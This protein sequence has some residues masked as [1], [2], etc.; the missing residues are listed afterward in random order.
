M[1]VPEAQ[2]GLY[3]A[4]GEAQAVALATPAA[5]GLVGRDFTL[6][7]WIQ[8]QGLRADRDLP[9]FGSDQPTATGDIQLLVRNGL[10]YVLLNG[11]AIT[12]NTPLQADCW[13]HVA[14]RYNATTGERVLLLNGVPD[15]AATGLITLDDDLTLMIGRLGS[16]Y[17][18]G[19]ITEVRLWHEAR[20]ND[21]LQANLYRRLN[22]QE[23]KL[24]GY[25]PLNEG[26]GLV[27]TDRRAPISES[28]G[29]PVS[30]ALHN[31]AIARD[32]WQPATDPPLR[33]L[34]PGVEAATV[35]VA[36]FPT[37]DAGLV[38]PNVP[39]LIITNTLTVE[40]WVRA[41]ASGRALEFYP[42]LSM[43]SDAKGWE[44]RCDGSQCAF[45]VTSNG[46]PYT[47]TSGDLAA[48]AWYHVAGVY[49]G[50]LVSLY[51][52]GV[53]RSILPCTGAITPYP[54]ALGIGCNTYWNDR[55]FTGQLAEVRLWGRARTQ[56]EIQQGLFR[57]LAG[58]E[59]GLI[60]V[61]SLE[62]DGSAS[63]DAISATPRGA[64]LWTRAGVPLPDTPLA[65]P[66]ATAKP[67]TGL[68][69]QLIAARARNAALV[70]Q[71]KEL[72]EARRAQE[73]QFI[74]QFEQLRKQLDDVTSQ[75]DYLTHQ[76]RQLLAA[77]DALTQDKAR[78]MAEKEELVKG[79]GARTTL[80]DFVQN[81]ND[82]IKRARAELRRQGGAYSLERVSLE[83]KMLPGPAGEGMFFPQQADLGKAEARLIEP[84]HLSTLSLEF[85]AHDPQEKPLITPLLVPSVIGYTEIMAR[86]KLVEAGFLV[87]R[88]FQAVVQK[89][90]EPIQA[91]RVVD[92]L[93]HPGEKWPP[94]GTITI[95]I[96]R[97]TVTG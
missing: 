14:L 6:E 71:N 57:R 34:T 17:F 32:A 10:L 95:F 90:N 66:D 74:K 63:N 27:A 65:E 39:A 20:T 33:L 16:A 73:A 87:A 91:D 75:L 96:G 85:T 51:V 37:V 1:L 21:Q 13:Y 62:G 72:T 26:A 36:E 46:A 31:G 83:V 97:E 42:L 38:A 22:G 25:W 3:F 12:G 53:R 60:G 70:Q 89:P 15:A 77:N 5:L 93:P 47:V 50:H 67:A 76:H 41:T 7:A 61:W 86:R 80:H 44:L 69:A 11:N 92:Q 81:A 49:D 23:Q 35:V 82:S 18:R 48:N 79:G 45:V 59:A 29:Q 52:N 54:G 78:L 56:A 94:G 19:L 58:D 64:V 88:D 2:S 68:R 9:V 30:V 4:E 8:P 28:H 84:D 24:A 40:A 55:S 43:F